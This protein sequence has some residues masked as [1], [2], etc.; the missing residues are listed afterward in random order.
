MTFG[1]K[2]TLLV[3]SHSAIYDLR[4][5]SWYLSTF[6]IVRFM[7]L[8]IEN[9]KHQKVAE[10]SGKRNVDIRWIYDFLRRRA[11]P[12]FSFRSDLEPAL[13]PQPLTE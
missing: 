5:L 1:A 10:F 7:L 4:A 9:Q 11:S 13:N 6:G 8:A 3:G 2:P 12:Y